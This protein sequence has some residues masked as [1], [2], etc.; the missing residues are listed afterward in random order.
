MKAATRKPLAFVGRSRNELNG[1]PDSARQD[2][3]YQLDRV[4][5]GLSPDR[6]DQL[7]SIG[8]GVLEIKVDEYREAFRVVYVAAF[9]ETAEAIAA[10]SESLEI[11]RAA[12]AGANATSTSAMKLAG[13]LAASGR[14]AEAETLLL[15]VHDVLPAGATGHGPSRATAARALADLYDA[16]GR[17]G[18]ARRYRAGSDEPDSG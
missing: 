3:G 5:A 15:E 7:P 18:D 1:F 12:G 4:Q 2:A 8:R 6:F 16:W 14:F 10:Q 17:P 9:P 13:F 11:L